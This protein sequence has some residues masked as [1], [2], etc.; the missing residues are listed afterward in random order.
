MHPGNGSRMLR[1]AALCHGRHA[2]DRPRMMA[3]PVACA[4]GP[5]FTSALYG[6]S[7]ATGR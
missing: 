4:R 3:L 2:E 7:P 5:K 6:S 1:I